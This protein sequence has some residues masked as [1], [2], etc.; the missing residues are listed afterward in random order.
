MLEICVYSKT[1]KRKKIRCI[2]YLIQVF[3]SYF[4][5][6]LKRKKGYFVIFSQKE[7]IKEIATL[8]L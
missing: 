5:W 4:S 6:F 3:D 1:I 7:M 8:H 2:R